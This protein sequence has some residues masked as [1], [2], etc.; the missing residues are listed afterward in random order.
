MKKLTK[1]QKTLIGA[2]A[3]LFVIVLIVMLLKPLLFPAKGRLYG[4]R[5]EGINKV[6]IS[7][8]SEENLINVYKNIEGVKDARVRVNGK[9]IHLLVD[10]ED[11]A[12]FNKLKEASTKVTENLSESEKAF[13]DVEVFFLGNGENF[14]IIGYLHKSRSAFVWSNNVN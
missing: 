5:L 8:S 3:L 10:V 4:N 13:Y 12:D 11:N 14:P 1:N 7:K 6:K 2:G 9:I